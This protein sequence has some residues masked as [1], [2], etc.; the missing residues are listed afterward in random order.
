M[1]TL[2]ER[3]SAFRRLHEAGCFVLPNPWDVGTA[4][5]LARLG[6]QALGTTS[7]GV[8]YSRG[9]RAADWLECDQMLAHVAELVAATELPVTADFQAGYAA[10]PA[11]VAANVRRCIDTGAAGLSIEDSTSDPARPLYPVDEAVQRVRA[12][13]LAIDAA[14]ADVVLTAR[15]ECYLVGHPEP[16]TESIRRLTAYAGAGADVLYA[17]GLRSR[18]EIETVVSAVAPRPVNL[19]MG[20]GAGFTVAEVAAMGVRRISVGSAMARAAFTGLV[21][22]ALPLIER[23]SFEGFEGTLPIAEIDDLV[24]PG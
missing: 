1:P 21:R 2:A 5:Y 11:G 24:Q 18:Q 9:L 16:L 15:A 13:R 20:A 12:A 19:L 6:F 23:G 8:G 22:A 4:R 14:G 10:D 3:R 17:P 7:A